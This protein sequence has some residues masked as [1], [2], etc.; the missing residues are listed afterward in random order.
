MERRVFFKTI[1]LS[2]VA[3]TAI[4]NSKNLL[5]STN[6]D[7]NGK[8]IIEFYCYGGA[9]F[10]FLFAP[11]DEGE[12]K[13]LYFDKQSDIIFP[14]D[15]QNIKIDNKDYLIR[16]DANQLIDMFQNNEIAIIP[17]TWFS[18]NRDH[19]YSSKKTLISIEE[20]ITPINEVQ[21]SWIGKISGY[22]NKNTISL[23]TYF[24]YATKIDD[25]FP[26]SKS[27]TAINTRPFGIQNSNNFVDKAL[28][29]FYLKSESQNLQAKHFL[30]QQRNII[31]LS[32]EVNSFLETKTPVEPTT[33]SSFLNNQIVSLFDTIDANKI[34]NSSNYFLNYGS[35]DLHN[36]LLSYNYKYTN[37]FGDKQGLYTIVQ[38][39]KKRNLWNDTVIVINSEFGR[40]IKQNGRKGKD[41]GHGNLLFV[42]GGAVNGGIYGDMFPQSE[43]DKF[44]SS[45][46]YDIEG[47]TN[48][49]AIYAKIADFISQGLGET[50]YENIQDV[51][52]EQ[53]FELFKSNA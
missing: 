22:T 41:H 39:L 37:V 35:F 23:T 13:E 52:I 26:D 36:E 50:I 30:N 1:A 40:Q 44:K 34:F 10:R 6:F 5:S 32:K 12:Y 8:Q 43:I 25:N 31:S 17:N 47:K 15:Y 7:S 45:V 9:D 18:P 2:L 28:E 29:R 21:S 3:T 4:F 24:S 48:G 33:T 51:Q 14:E 19:N 20:D 11:F 38:E 16:K 46:G 49:I 53:E 42:A 27:I